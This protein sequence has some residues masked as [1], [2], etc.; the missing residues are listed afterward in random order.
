MNDYTYWPDDAASKVKD[1][2]DD[3]LGLTQSETDAMDLFEIN[4]VPSGY[5]RELYMEA[6]ERDEIDHLIW[7]QHCTDAVLRNFII[8]GNND[9]RDPDGEYYPRWSGVEVVAKDPMNSR[10]AMKIMDIL[11]MSSPEAYYR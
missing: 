8:Q 5:Y 9:Y 6:W 2:I 10:L 11:D 1:V 3:I 4:M 7:P